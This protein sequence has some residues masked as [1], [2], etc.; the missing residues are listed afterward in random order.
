MN[1]RE[2]LEKLIQSTQSLLNKV[3]AVT[4]WHRHGNPIPECKL[5]DLCDR[6]IDVEKTLRDIKEK[7]NV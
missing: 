6:Q 1:D 3:N 5:D 7:V 4:A 2:L